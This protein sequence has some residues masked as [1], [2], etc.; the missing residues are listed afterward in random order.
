VSQVLCI[1]TLLG[2]NKFM[3]KQTISS[4]S[5]T[6]TKA[7]KTKAKALSKQKTQVGAVPLHVIIL[8][9]GK[10]K[11]M[12]SDVPKVLHKV[13]GKPLL[14]HVL[15]AA[16][17]LQ[18]T[19]IHVV[20]REEMDLPQ[21]EH[22]LFVA[23]AAATAA[24]L[25]MP[26]INWVM[27]HEQLGTGH[28][29]QQVLPYLAAADQ[30]GDSVADDALVILLYGDVPLIKVE[31]IRN[32]LQAAQSSED[33]ITLVTASVPD[34][35][36]YGRIVRQH[37]RREDE[38]E[39]KAGD[40]IAIIEEKDADEEQRKINE[41]NSGVL[42]T[43]VKFLRQYLPRVRPHNHQGEY[44]LTDIIALVLADGYK[45]GNILVNDMQEI[46][47]V[48]DK[49][50][51]ATIER[52][53]QMRMATRLM[54]QQGVTLLDPQRLDVRGEVETGRDVTIDVNVVLEGSVKL[55]SRV[56]IG[57]NCY[58]KDVVIGDDV[59]VRPN[60]MIEGA[61]IDDNCVIGPF[62]RLRPH[63]KLA[64]GVHVGNFVEVKNSEIGADSKANHLSYVGDAVIGR[65]VNVGAGTITCNYDGANKHQTNIEDEVFIGSNTALVAPVTIK[66][67]ATI[68][69]G[70]TITADAP[71]NQ[72]TIARARQ[73]TIKDWQR[74][75]QSQ[76]HHQCQ[77][78]HQRTRQ[79][80]NNKTKGK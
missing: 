51:L 64:H 5:T 37:R 76:R 48:N 73:T 4:R 16:L 22:E 38:L 32:L 62:A 14:A 27:Q 66:S 53:Y 19:M 63:S 35:I 50:Q 78:Q 23:S 56:V 34:P 68:A 28:A 33:A 13:A 42:C 61:V 2:Q 55:G 54:R 6:K 25:Q 75:C 70:S 3:K 15:D 69:A 71:A 41:I 40:I 44:Y 24:N 12:H 39:D 30:C 31:T 1:Y 65:K 20:C 29:V 26:P 46:L 45:V 18:P 8:A 47:G 7:N 79:Y 9:A 57:A 10:G 77:C 72:L 52:Y 17:A 74:P 67:G 49:T 21:R 36:G 80:S 58:L 59:E 11:R 60:S 43:S